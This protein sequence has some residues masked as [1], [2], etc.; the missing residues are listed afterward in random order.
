MPSTWTS[1]APA[2]RQYP[3]L[4]PA[5]RAA[6]LRLLP[7]PAC[8]PPPISALGLISG[9]CQLLGGLACR[10]SLRIYVPLPSPTGCSPVSRNLLVFGF[11][12]GGFSRKGERPEGASTPWQL[13]APLPSPSLFRLDPIPIG[14]KCGA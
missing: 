3:P 1:P 10:G 4:V 11:L 7:C 5:P 13:L 12:S 14:R 6:C 2:S 9:I 8:A